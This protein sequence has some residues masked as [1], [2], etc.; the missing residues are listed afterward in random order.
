MNRKFETGGAETE[1]SHGGGAGDAA[2][3]R[4][5]VLEGTAQTAALPALANLRIKVFHEF[6]YLYD[7]DL[8][9]ERKYLSSYA[10]S[11]SSVIVGAFDGGRLIGAATG[12]PLAKEKGAWVAPLIEKGYKA[13]EV[14]YFGESVLL[15]EY[16]GRGIGHRFFDLREEVARRQ[17]AKHTA[18]VA[19]M[20]P[21]DHPARPAD[22]RP[23]DA[24]WRKRGYAPVDGAV[25][26][27]EWREIGD[28]V[29]TS[30]QLQYWAR[31]L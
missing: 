5:Q 24:F 6:P 16:R 12:A 20:R 1:Q 25:A 13:D 23:L 27:F 7:G 3:I 18:F 30:H 31:E 8:D 22:Y 29:E 14:F 28:K 19:V 26:E 15:S 21:E 11:S 4:V 9:Y 17:N 2:S 10:A